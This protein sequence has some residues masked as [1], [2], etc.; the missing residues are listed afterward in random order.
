MT[1]DNAQGVERVAL[2]DRPW[3][4]VL[5]GLAATIAAWSLAAVGQRGTGAWLLLGGGLLAGVRAITVR[6]PTAK[7]MLTA[8]LVPLL[9]A[10]AL[11]PSWDTVVLLFRLAAVVAVAA[12]GLLALPPRAQRQ[13]LSLLV[14]CHFGGI[15]AVIFSHAPPDA[16]A[17]WLATQ[18]EGRVY[19][20]YLECLYLTSTYRFYTPRAQPETLLW[21]HLTYADGSGRWIKLPEADSR[22]NLTTLRMLQLN[23][24]VQVDTNSDLSDELL[25]AREQ[26]GK[27]FAPPMPELG[28]DMSQEYQPPTPDGKTFLE[29]IARYLAH[30]YPH[31]DDPEQAVTGV[32][33]Y[34]VVHSF[35][36]REE[37]LAQVDPDDPTTY[38]AY[39]QGHFG[40]DGK[41]KPSCSRMVQVNGSEVEIR[42]D[43][44]LYWRIP[45]VRNEDGSI[46]DYVQL[47][48]ELDD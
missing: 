27:Q 1:T 3:L 17:S 35:L 15:A 30:H 22:G 41:L 39:Y 47:H 31:P 38:L 2:W 24:M 48:A 40:P 21:A 42:Q 25:A 23:G 9:A 18:L 7:L 33:I 28:D 6:W 10:Q 11:D 37:V 29:S 4:L 13:I 16:P 36:T 5:V 14:V 19:R 32:K 12:A 43:H 45:I 8:A 46:T 44:F 34:C 20:P 26:A